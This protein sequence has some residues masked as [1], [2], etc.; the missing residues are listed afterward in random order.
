MSNSTEP[1]ITQSKRL[2]LLLALMGAALF[3][4]NTCCASDI[5]P[6]FLNTWNSNTWS[7]SDWK[8]KSISTPL[9]NSIFQLNDTPVLFASDQEPYLPFQRQRLE[10]TF[11]NPQL[12]DIDIQPCLDCNETE[13]LFDDEPAGIFSLRHDTHRFFSML[14]EDARDTVTLKNSLFLGVAL[15]G[16]LAIRSNLDDSVR[17]YTARSPNRWGDTSVGFGKL[18]EPQFQIPA[19][20]LLYG[21]SKYQK[22]D[23][24][25]DV[26][27]S[28]ISA[29]T[30]TALST[31]AIKAI[32]NT[33]RPSDT[34]NNGQYGFPS[35]HTST[36]FAMAAV[37]EEYYGLRAGIPAYALAG[38]V[39]WSRIDERDHD[40]SDV[41]FGAA[42][43]YVIGKSIAGKHRLGNSDLQISP[44]YHPI[45]GT[46]GIQFE[47][48]F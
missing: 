27:V 3:G 21:Y 48:S 5:S 6:S 2:L 11:E 42:L 28:L 1:Q 16:S 47:F 36:N 43:G 14:W 23:H 24:L 33:E 38:L 4:S 25:H 37:I 22:N 12:F 45:N 17:R 19:L 46:S 20:L 13:I 15:G 41:V 26:S 30:I 40:L 39:G 44:Y 31:V 32:A 18:G 29:Y 34:W 35:F 10:P 8:T 7:L 9:V